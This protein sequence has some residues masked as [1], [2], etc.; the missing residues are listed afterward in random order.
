MKKQIQ[1]LEVE[2]HIKKKI[3]EWINELSLNCK[4][5]GIDLHFRNFLVFAEVIFDWYES[6]LKKINVFSEKELKETNR[7]INIAKKIIKILK[8]IPPVVWDKIEKIIME[9]VKRN[10]RML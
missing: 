9:E 3:S 5:Q 8:T 10:E 6:E 1:I 7:K 4:K 2:K